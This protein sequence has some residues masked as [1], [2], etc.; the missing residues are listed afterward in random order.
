MIH[1]LDSVKLIFLRL[2]ATHIGIGPLKHR[3]RLWLA[4]LIGAADKAPVFINNCNYKL[5]AV[6]SLMDRN[7]C[8]RR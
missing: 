6:R 7:P 3:T 4:A 2:I 5:Q 8:T 1:L